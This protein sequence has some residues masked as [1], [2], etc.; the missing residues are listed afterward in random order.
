MTAPPNLVVRGGT[1]WK[2]FALTGIILFSL[3]VVYLCIFGVSVEP[4]SFKYIFC[5]FD[6]EYPPL[7][8]YFLRL[9]EII[10]P[11]LELVS[12]LQILIFSCTAALFIIYFSGNRKQAVVFSL[13][14]G[15][16]PI[17]S[18]FCTDILSE[19]LFIPLLFCFVI[20]I[21]SF[22]KRDKYSIF[23]VLT[24]GIIAALLYLTRFAGLLL[25]FIF[26]LYSVITPI[27]RKQLWLTIILAIIS[28]QIVL[29]PVRIKYKQIVGTY[30]IP[31]NSGATLWNNASVLYIGSSAQTNPT[32]DFEKFLIHSDT[33]QFNTTNAIKGYQVNSPQ[34]PFRSYIAEKHYTQLNGF[35]P[36][37]EARITAVKL[38][39]EHPWAYLTKFVVPNFLQF[40]SEGQHNKATV[41]GDNFKGK[42]LVKEYHSI[43]NYPRVE[44]RILY[45][46]LVL[47][48]LLYLLGR[49]PLISSIILGIFSLYMIIL[50]F[51]C[52]LMMRYELILFPLILS[53][54][55]MQVLKLQR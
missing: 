1:Y 35:I 49:R 26:L 42:H 39:K 53:S 16:D 17:S 30:R 38:I 34:F 6:F 54:L 47:S 12:I 43:N 3:K 40:F 24:I 7:Y 29:I 2:N 22:F 55:F 23:I 46:L 4:D 37:N 32:T 50:P 31:D 15:L 45:T 41:Y 13:L 8:P 11:S 5:V 33:S 25:L 36:S 48:I 51:T 14:L 20:A 19:A 18:H 10:Y 44:W 9:I 52:P 21:H 28:F 27:H